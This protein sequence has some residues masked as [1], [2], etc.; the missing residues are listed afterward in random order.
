MSP[1]VGREGNGTLKRDGKE[2]PPKRG[3][4]GNGSKTET[5]EKCFKKRNE[6]PPNGG[7]KRNTTK[8]HRKRDG[9][10]MLV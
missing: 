2:M 6:I 5:G 7:L 9:K 4:E 3:Q 1:K 8:C 10:E